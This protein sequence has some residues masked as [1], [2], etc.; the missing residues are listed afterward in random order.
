MEVKDKIII[1]RKGQ[2][3][4]EKLNLLNEAMPY[5]NL[6]SLSD[7]KV[8][9]NLELLNWFVDGGEL[10]VHMQDFR[11]PYRYDFLLRKDKIIMQYILTIPHDLNFDLNL[12]FNNYFNQFNY[13]IGAKAIAYFLRNNTEMKLINHYNDNDGTY[14][15]G[16]LCDH[17]DHRKKKLHHI[18]EYLIRKTPDIRDQPVKSVKQNTAKAFFNLT[19]KNR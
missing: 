6:L 19:T 8:I 2:G 1:K 10:L 14:D 16:W 13:L 17:V 5:F 7:K 4:A 12:P 9:H 18:I 15:E 3:V 11:S